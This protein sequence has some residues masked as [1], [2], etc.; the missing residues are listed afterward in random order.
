MVTYFS[1]CLFNYLNGSNVAAKGLLATIYIMQL[2][3]FPCQHPVYPKIIFN[4]Y[5]RQIT[6]MNRGL[7]I[8]INL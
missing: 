6:K 5:H 7:T 2:I 1:E 8:N 4:K 3:S